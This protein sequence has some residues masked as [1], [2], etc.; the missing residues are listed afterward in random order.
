MKGLLE[1]ER[2]KEGKDTRLEEGSRLRFGA[3][4]KHC[5][6]T[7]MNFINVDIT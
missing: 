4:L 3:L 5:E 1:K 7:L 6:N 2:P